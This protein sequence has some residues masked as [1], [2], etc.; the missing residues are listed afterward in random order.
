MSIFAPRL[1]I[2]QAGIVLIGCLLLESPARAQLFGDRTVGQ[3][4]RGRQQQTRPP[5]LGTA[6]GGQNV[7]GNQEAV[8]ILSGNE[9]FLR[10]NRSR[11][12]FVGSNRANQSGF[13]VQ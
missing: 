3:P 7:G 8:G 12:D 4:L 13:A 10:G 11:N 5:Q 9:R 6:P 1:R 2:V